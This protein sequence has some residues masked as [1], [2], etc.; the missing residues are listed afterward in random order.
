MKMCP[1]EAGESLG[2]PFLKQ[3]S[4]CDSIGAASGAEA[5]NSSSFKYERRQSIVHGI[6]I[7]MY[8]IENASKCIQLF[9]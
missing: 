5:S 8:S 3:S 7:A 6:L 9:Q 1:L 4:I 2:N